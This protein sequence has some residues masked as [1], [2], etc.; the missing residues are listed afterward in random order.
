[1]TL[2]FTCIHTQKVLTGIKYYGHITKKYLTLRMDE[3]VRECNVFSDLFLFFFFP[4]IKIVR[5]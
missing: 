1:M 4:G 3:R 5:K 2:T